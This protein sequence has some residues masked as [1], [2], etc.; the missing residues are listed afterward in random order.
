MFSLSVIFS[1][2]TIIS[3]ISSTQIACDIMCVQIYRNSHQR[4]SLKKVI[5]KISLISQENTWSLSLIKL[6]AWGPVTLL[7]RDSNTD[8]FLWN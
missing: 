3:V 1:I 2:D 4:C 7:K 8:A 5:L 6:Q